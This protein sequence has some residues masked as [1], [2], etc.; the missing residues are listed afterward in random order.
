MAFLIKR[1]SDLW[2]RGSHY[3]LDLDNCG[4]QE[5]VPLFPSLL[6]GVG[7]PGIGC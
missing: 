2:G 3:A 7:L 4:G 1:I 5:A 6:I